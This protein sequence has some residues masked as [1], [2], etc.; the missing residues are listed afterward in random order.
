MIE[1]N[2]LPDI[3]QEFVRAKRQKRVVIV[4]MILVSA[5]SVGLVVLLGS[6]AYVGQLVRQKIAD[7]EISNLS[8]ELSGK[9]NLV[10]NLTVQNQLETVDELHRTKGEYGRMFDYLKVLNPE[11]PNNVSISKATLDTGE[12]TILIEASAKDYPAVTVFKDTLQNAKL[13]YVDPES[14][15]NKKKETPLFEE[16]T[17]S[18]PGITQNTLGQ[19]VTAFKA[20]LKYDPLAF[21][22]IIQNPS[23]KIPKGKTNQSA[24]KVSI[25]ADAPLKT[26]GQ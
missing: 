26:E 18:E 15:D 21:D 8:K 10:R 22:W 12:G 17:I 20:T 23:I 2:L 16:V 13:V 14:G 25:F 9:K 7:G 11:A 19:Q 5:A 6:Y 1:L 4:A 24:D 3:K